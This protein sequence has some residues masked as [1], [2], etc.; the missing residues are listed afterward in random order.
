MA[1]RTPEEYFQ[2]LRDGRVVYS[3]GKKV[4]DVTKDPVL[5]LCANGC[6]L[7]YAV[8]N[9]PEYYDKFIIE[10][11]AGEEVSFVFF[12]AKSAGDLLRRREIIQLLSRTFFG[13]PCGAKFT[14]IDGLHSL[15][16]NSRI[17]DMALG[18]KYGAKVEEYRKL[19]MKNDCAM[20]VAMTDVKGDRSVRPSRQKPHQ[21]YYVRIVDETK[22]C[23]QDGIIV[24]GAKM[25]ITF[26]ACSNEIIVMPCR[27]MSEEDKDY[28]VAFACTPAT[29]GITIISSVE[30]PFEAGNE[31]DYP[32][33]SIKHSASGCIIF[34][35]VFIPMERVFL[36]KEWQY[37]G[38]FA[39]M[40]AHFHRMSGDAY[41]Y[42]FLEIATG[43]GALLAEYNGLEKIAH[44][45]DKLAWLVL[46]A[47]GV[48]ALGKA[49]CQFCVT[50]P[51][52]DLVYPNPI[53]SNIAKFFFADHWH[54]AAKIIQDIAGGL[55]ATAFSAKDY[56]NPET[57]PLIDR[58]FGGKDG[59]S[60][61]DR[62]RAMH[63]CREVTGSFVDVSTIHSEGSL[64]AQRLA[65]Y[66]MGD[67][68]RYK[69]AAKRAARIND[70]RQHPVFSRLPNLVVH[71]F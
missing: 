41:R 28:A 42:P 31:F 17:M 19:L 56:F 10:D 51:G 71:S 25:F 64:A 21:D 12:P 18:S 1:I 29:K 37:S 52:T 48:E 16:V 53:Y 44:V 40:F 55:P 33:A 69:T 15:T 4:Q 47:E 27:A 59:I 9:M 22:Q 70:G 20:V 43:L 36:K 57:R 35:D 46:Y 11:D 13:S 50:Q 32:I 24:R 7:D 45:R 2:S 23:G 67:W 38:N 6:A 60:A 39:H 61:E 30:Q 68:E 58:Y 14:G 5:S 65:L 49:S 34:D 66:A 63:L 62:L 26:A 3:Q 8:S 54:E